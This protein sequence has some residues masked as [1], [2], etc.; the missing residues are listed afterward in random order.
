MIKE[1]CSAR[2]QIGCDRLAIHLVNDG[3]GVLMEARKGK[4]T[5][6]YLYSMQQIEG[7]QFDFLEVFTEYAKS[8]FEERRYG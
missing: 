2:E 4:D 7:G 3:K 1:M 6:H 5:I 8:L